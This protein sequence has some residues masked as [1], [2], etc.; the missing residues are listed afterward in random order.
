MN[1]VSLLIL[2]A[3]IKSRHDD[4]RL[5]VAAVALVVLLAAIAFSK[6]R[7]AGLDAGLPAAVAPVGPPSNGELAMGG[8]RDDTLR[9]AIDRWIYD[10]GHEEHELRERLLQV[11]R[12]I[13][14]SSPT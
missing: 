12:Q 2:P 4:Y 3:V 11:K 5:G 14:S 9:A 13:E 6:R 7:T 1:L 8:S 10:L